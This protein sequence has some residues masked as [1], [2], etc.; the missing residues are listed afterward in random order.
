MRFTNRGK[1]ERA[2]LESRLFIFYFFY[3]LLF[4]SFL[5]DYV[6]LTIE[7]RIQEKRVEET[8]CNQENCYDL[9]FT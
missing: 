1:N 4:S 2:K 8:N 6:Y 7:F 9:K 3:Y 5:S